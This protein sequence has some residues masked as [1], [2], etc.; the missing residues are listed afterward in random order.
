MKLGLVLKGFNMLLTSE[1]LK[2]I[3]AIALKEKRV[4]LF[5][6]KFPDRL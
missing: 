2:F 4:F 3:Y 5:L 1:Y 6:G